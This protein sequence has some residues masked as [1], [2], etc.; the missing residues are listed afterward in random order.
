MSITRFF[1]ALISATVLTGAIAFAETK[2]GHGDDVRMVLTVADHTNHRPA[3]LKPG[4]LVITDGTI[5]DVTPLKGRDLEVF[6][7]IDDAANVNDDFS[8][9]LQALRH[10]VTTQPDPVAIGVAYIHGGMLQVV[11]NPTTDHQRAATALRAPAG[12]E[13]ANP[14]S[15]LSDL[16]QHWVSDS[17]SREIVLVGM[18]IDDSAKDGGSCANAETAI[19]DAQ[20]AGVIVYALYN[21]FSSIVPQNSSKLDATAVDLGQVAYQTG[22]EAYFIGHSPTATLEPFLA[23]ISEHLANRYL[24]KFRLTSN[25]GSGLQSVNVNAG[26][27]DQELMAPDKVWVV[28]ELTALSGQ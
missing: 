13:P 27:A 2:S 24:V 6:M 28:P 25:T 22:G 8:S 19:Q 11:E 20:R 10:F 7:V 1:A 15:A 17:V 5:A 18:Q 26:S 9:R 16:I 12:S 23:D 14:Y 3:V 21:P 4:G